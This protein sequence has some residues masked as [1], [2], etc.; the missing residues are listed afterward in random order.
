[1]AEKK[2]NSIKKRILVFL[3]VF[4]FLILIINILFGEKGILDVIKYRNEISKLEE[5]IKKLEKKKRKLEIEIEFL[6]NEK[7]AVEPVARKELGYIKEGEKLL[8]I[9]D[10]N[11]KKK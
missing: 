3:G 7:Y 9:N 10:N 8:I 1:M 4:V 6:E 11:K 2:E 5:K